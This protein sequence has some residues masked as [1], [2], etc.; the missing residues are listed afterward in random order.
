MAHAHRAHPSHAPGISRRA[1]VLGSIAVGIVVVVLVVTFALGSS[2]SSPAPATVNGAQRVDS[3]LQGIPQQGT[4]LGSPSAPAT[5]VEF[6]DLQCPYCGVWARDALP[7][8]VDRYVRTGKLRIVFVGMSF[9]GPDSVKAL[10][11]A[12]AAGQHNRFWN[13]VELLYENQ[14]TENGG[15]VT[16]SLLRGIGAAVPGLDAERMLA[17]SGSPAVSRALAQADASA[18]QAGINA[19][20]SFA[21]ASPGGRLHIVRPAN[22][23]AAGIEPQIEAALR[24]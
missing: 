21:L 10:R 8:V 16:D 19:T 24:R 9:L 3:L 17:E 13:V 7:E 22:L 4:A 20:P 6:A 23:S 5:L 2:S 12:L 15:W 18:R 14:G 11:A 1:L